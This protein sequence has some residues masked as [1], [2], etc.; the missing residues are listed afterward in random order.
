MYYKKKREIFSYE[1]HCN[2]LNIYKYNFVDKY[3]IHF[4]YKCL[5]RSGKETSVTV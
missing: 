3:I 1:R 4:T 2:L 5:R